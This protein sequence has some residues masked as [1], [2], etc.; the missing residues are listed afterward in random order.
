LFFSSLSD[1]VVLCSLMQR[2]RPGSI[3]TIHGH[4]GVPPKESFRKRENVGFFLNALVDVA[5]LPA[6]NVARVDPASVIG[7]RCTVPLLAVLLDLATAHSASLPYPHQKKF[8]ASKH[9]VQHARELLAAYV[10]SSD[11]L[12]TAPSSALSGEQQMQ[13]ARDSAAA[14]G[15][16]KSKL[17]QLV[18]V[19][20]CVRM[21]LAK[22]LYARMTRDRYFR[23]RTARELLD[24]EVTYLRGL[25][26]LEQ[27]YVKRLK[28]AKDAYGRLLLSVEEQTV[29][30]GGLL[31]LV[32]VSRDFAERLERRIANWRLAVQVGDVFLKVADSLKLYSVYVKAFADADEL[33]KRK[34]AASKEFAAFLTQ[35]QRDSGLA[36]DLV[37][38]LITPVQRLPRY[39]LLLRELLQRT[40]AAHPDADLVRRALHEVSAVARYVNDR[41]RDADSQRA[42]A[43]AQRRITM[44]PRDFVQPHRAL[45]REDDVLVGAK[46]DARRIFLMSDLLIVA[47]RLTRLERMKEDDGDSLLRYCDSLS[48]DSVRLRPIDAVTIELV[49]VSRFDVSEPADAPLKEKAIVVTLRSESDM[50]AWLQRFDDVQR[51]AATAILPLFPL[52]LLSDAERKAL[53]K[54]HD[55]GDF[56]ITPP[57]FN[58]AATKSAKAQFLRQAEPAAQAVTLTRIHR[59]VSDADSDDNEAGTALFRPGQDRQVAAPAAAA[60]DDSSSSSTS[61]PSS[62]Y[63]SSSSSSSAPDDVLSPRAARAA[64]SAARPQPISSSD[65]GRRLSLRHSRGSVESSRRSLRH[66][67]GS[68]I[69]SSSAASTPE[70]ARRHR[71]RHRSYIDQPR[72]DGAGPP[73]Y[74]R[75]DSLGLDEKTSTSSG[76]STPTQSEDAKRPS[77]RKSSIVQQPSPLPSPASTTTK[78]AAPAPAEEERVRTQIEVTEYLGGYYDEVVAAPL[79]SPKISSPPPLPV[80]R[81]PPPAVPPLDADVLAKVV[82]RTP[83]KI[84]AVVEMLSSPESTP[85]AHE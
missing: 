78:V 63:S 25:E 67:G 39:E 55:E 71:R 50:S 6:R 68:E 1:G 2:L 82:V 15:A 27:F 75:S 81:G 74:S 10:P 46:R 21:L 4:L 11:A 65:S 43:D 8:K 85:R 38:L 14:I 19:Q 51:S 23:E 61:S 69:L 66:T 48:M 76:R 40:D 33:L 83:P 58:E 84:L 72:A 32:E 34:L 36:L 77:R 16:S 53:R 13:R 20:S 41:Q 24:T 29:M 79:L 12:G 49:G 9:D 60:D 73:A 22:R 30:F 28:T 31:G 26:A 64:A 54:Q 57:I 62:S 47:R 35:C 18:V 70:S 44:R 80:V 56:V 3:P 42:L 37:S 7:C 5:H 17:A 52:P 45:L 59:S